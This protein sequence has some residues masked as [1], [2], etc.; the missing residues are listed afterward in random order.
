MDKWY[1]SLGSKAR[2]PY[3]DSQMRDKI[4]KGDLTASTLVYKEGDI[5]WLPLEDQK[6]WSPT[7]SKEQGLGFKESKINGGESQTQ[8]TNSWVLLVENP[9][10]KGDYQQQGPFSQKTILEKLD[11]GEVHLN[12]YC[13]TKG[14]K[15]WVKL[16][17]VPELSLAR[18]NS[19]QFKDTN[20]TV[21]PAH[22]KD[23]KSEAGERSS[24]ADKRSKVSMKTSP[25]VS[26]FPDFIEPHQS[27]DADDFVSELKAN[28]YEGILKKP[29][30]LP[31]LTAELNFKK[32]TR[33]FLGL[34]VI[35]FIAGLTIGYLNQK[36]FK[37]SYE[38]LKEKKATVS[39]FFTPNFVASYLMVKPS[40]LEKKIIR[41][42][43][44]APEGSKILVRVESLS[45]Q[46]MPFTKTKKTHTYVQVKSAGVAELD[47]SGFDL[48]P[49]K[50]YFIYAEM[51]G[52]KAKKQVTFVP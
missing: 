48:K 31:S 32:Q 50:N 33:F 12:D 24:E 25:L 30:F 10:K 23:F 19:I 7:F 42:K 46:S 2:G 14:M 1:V 9:I 3:S 11:I 22:S 44:D 39:S 45:G 28:T 27:V 43:T 38:W 51:A 40:I 4:K 41:F 52:L 49:F 29:K 26:D 13:W 34:V 17:D 18:K 15:G 5:D 8:L 16:L 36:A 21:S 6:I 37:Q 47:I 20:N 35:L